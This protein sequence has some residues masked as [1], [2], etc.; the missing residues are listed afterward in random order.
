[1]PEYLSPGVYVEE[2]ELGPRP[3]EGVSTSTAGFLGE[4]LRGPDD[5]RFITGFEEFKR[6]YGG[7]VPIDASTLPFAIDGFFKNGGQRCFVA[8]ITSPDAVFMTADHDVKIRFRA[9]G[10]GT[11][12]NRIAAKIEKATLQV[13][14]EPDRFKLTVMYW[15]E[16]V[17]PPTAPPVDPTLTSTLTDV[18]RREPTLLEVYDNLSVVSTS[19]DFF[20]TTVNGS[21][22][23]VRVDHIDPNT[24]VT[25]PA[26][27]PL[28]MLASGGTAGA[29][30]AAV[31]RGD[32]VGRT[33]NTFPP[34]NTSYK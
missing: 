12:G 9:I 17:A 10:P 24:P 6:L 8:R 26:L 13:V 1:M 5:I 22:S 14:G 23:L 34:D 3:I 31:V 32:Y 25:T 7:Y 19:I 20:E 33:S 18:N 11:W 4:T 2:I 21:S 29:N 30:G 27:K 28:A 16:N 15:D